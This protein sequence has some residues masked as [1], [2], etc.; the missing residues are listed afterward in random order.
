[1]AFLLVPF[2]W[3]L[4]E[5]IL[6]QKGRKTQLC[7]STTIKMKTTQPIRATHRAVPQHNKTTLMRQ[8]KKNPDAPPPISIYNQ[9]LILEKRKNAAILPTLFPA[10]DS[11]EQNRTIRCQSMNTN[12]KNVVIS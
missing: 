10:A 7:A 5:K 2:L 3:P 11:A 9:P 6:A 8:H 4:K 1:V 12:V